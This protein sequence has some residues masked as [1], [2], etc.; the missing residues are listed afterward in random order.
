M[1]K[2][3]KR[4]KVI[5]QYHRKLSGI[6]LQPQKKATPYTYAY[7]NTVKPANTLTESTQLYDRSVRRDLLK[8]LILAAT[9]IGG[10]IGLSLIIK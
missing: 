10:E 3:T 4:E 1:P 5:A 6:G 2:K 9:A 8:T 7:S